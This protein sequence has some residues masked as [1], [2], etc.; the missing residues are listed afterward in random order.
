M[1]AIEGKKFV[2][3]L[4]IYII[5]EDYF[6]TLIFIIHNSESYFLHLIVH[7]ILIIKKV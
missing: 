2:S 4:L 1:I 7:D 6:D 5:Q 3:I